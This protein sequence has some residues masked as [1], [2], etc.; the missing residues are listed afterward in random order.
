MTKKDAQGLIASIKEFT[1][2][3][4]VKQRV[5]I[6]YQRKFYDERIRPR[7][8]RCLAEEKEK[9]DK[10]VA[11]GLS[12]QLKEPVPLAIR[13]KVAKESWDEED[14]EFRDAFVEE[15]GVEYQEALDTFLNRD[16]TPSTPEE[17]HK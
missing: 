1:A 6:A 11:E 15:I 10:A 7:Y 17:Y 14:P 9:W 13:N 4:P 12:D 8:E 5:L 16:L 3:K 2:P